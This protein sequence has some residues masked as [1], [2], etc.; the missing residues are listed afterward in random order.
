[1]APGTL[2]IGHTTVRCQYVGQDPQIVLI[3]LMTTFLPHLPSGAPLYAETIY[4]VA[5]NGPILKYKQKT[6][7]SRMF[8]PSGFIISFAERPEITLCGI[9]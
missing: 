9:N 8:I 4:D 2:E 1:M 5:I 3:Q 7:L 6:E